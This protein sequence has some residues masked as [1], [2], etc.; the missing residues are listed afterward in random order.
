MKHIKHF[1]L[2]ISLL[3]TF[4][5]TVNAQTKTPLRR[6]ISPSSPV[7]L[8]HIDTHTWPDPQKCIDLIPTDIRPYLVMNISLSAGD[9]VRKKY[10]FT[11]CESW[12]RTCAE[13]RI[14]ATIQPASGYFC[15][16][17]DTALDDYE[18]FYKYPNFLG[19]NFAEQNW[20]FPTL[21]D[22]IT[23]LDLFTNLL[24]IANKYGGYLMVSNFLPLGNNSNAVGK[25]KMLPSFTAACKA[26][27]EN[28][29]VLDKF[30]SSSGYY[31]NE[32]GNLGT[33][34]SGYCGNY[35]IRFD[36]C[37]WTTSTTTVFPESSG[38]VAVLEHFMLTGATITDGPELT[39]AQ[40]IKQVSAVTNSSDGYT[41]KK[42]EVYDQFSNISIDN[43]R[44]IIDGTV[45]ILSKEEVIAR[46]KIAFVNDINDGDGWAT[47]NT[48]Q[49]LFTGLYAM[50]GE[51]SE[52]K[53][54][55]KKTGRYPSIPMVI[56]GGEYET[57]AFD[58]VVFKSKYATRWATQQ[59]KVNEFNA[60]FPSEYKGDMF[61]SRVKNKW[62]TYNPY[63]DVDTKSSAIIPLKYNTCDSIALNYSRY[64]LG[65]ITELEDKLTFYLNNYC[66]SSTYGMRVDTIKVYGSINEPTY[67][68]TDR[69]S[70]LA[71]SITKTWS[72]GVFSLTITHNGPLD[73]TINCSG[74]ATDRL[75]DYLSTKIVEPAPSP[76]Y[77]GPVQYEAENFDYKSVTSV[78]EITLPD[79]TAMGY[80]N[81][82]TN[83]Y[84]SLRDTVT[85]LKAGNYT[86][87]TKYCV[88]TGNV[89][90]LMRINGTRK[91]LNFLNTG[92][93][94]WSVNTQTITLKSGA[95]V[96]QFF[97]NSSSNN[98]YFDNI[99][100]ER[101]DAGVYNFSNDAASTQANTPAY[102]TQQSGSL[103]VVSYV[104][105]SSSTSNSLKAYTVGETN[106]T[107]VAD[108]ELFP[109][110]ATDY[111]VTWKGYAESTGG[112]NGMLLRGTGS[113]GSCAYANGMK[114]GY[115]FAS[116]YNSDGTVTLISYVAT[117]NGLT[118]KNSYTTSFQV[119]PNQLCF[120]RAKALGN[121]LSFECS[122]DNQTWEGA[123]STTFTDDSY[124]SG[125]TQLV[126]GLGSENLGW[127]MDDIQYSSGNITV[128]E[129]IMDGLNY[130][131][132]TGP[133]SVQSFNISG[134]SLTGDILIN[135]NEQFEISL[136]SESEYSSSLTLVPVDGTVP[137]TPIYVRLK[138]GLQVQAYSDTI[139]ISSSDIQSSYL[140]LNGAVTPQPMVKMYD[141]S[142][143]AASTSATTP[144]A[145]NMTIG[146]DNTATAGV[147]Q[148]TDANGLTSK[149]FKTYTVGQR[150][151]TGVVNLNLFSKTGTDYSVTW[152]EYIGSSATGYKVG[153]LLRG[154]ST[155][156]GSA[157]T[158]YVQ[159]LMQGYLFI[160]FTS[161]TST[162]F[163]IYKST[164]STSLN[165]LTNTSVSTLIPEVKQPVWYRASVSGSTNA[166][167]TFEYST[168]SVNWN[169]GSSASDNTS[170]FYKSGATQI[171]WGLSMTNLD[172]YFDDIIFNG[173]DTNSGSLPE[174]IVVSQASISGLNYTLGAGP[175]TS[176]Q[177][178]VS[179]T[180]LTNNVVITAPTNFEISLSENSSYSSTLTLPVVNGSVAETPVFVRLKTGLALNTYNGTLTLTSSGVL[181]KMVSLTGEVTLAS[182]LNE[183]PNSNASVISTRYYTLT[184]LEVR[185]S[186]NL[187][188]LYLV[189]KY[190]SDG[191]VSVSVALF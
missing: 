146:T 124:V 87:K 158:G 180:P 32:S 134:T 118:E 25:L 93:D 33:Y 16:F 81:F 144:P 84:A 17:S 147:V 40:A 82:G 91:Y 133:S 111:S 2:I 168:D 187:K 34:L 56:N 137:V 120:F 30:T 21:Q 19:W 191:A 69:S 161:G 129:F 149:M 153:M 78:S 140:I 165:T 179:G 185:P 155:N 13:N 103:G 157:S 188:G 55:F 94:T 31:D 132:G 67:T 164:S 97:S 88:P 173:L 177:L 76:I 92:T 80:V 29:V 12:I 59:A 71:S 128:S 126:W 23:R 99:I 100:I 110:T 154:Q 50:D 74:N 37:G 141:F 171:V 101:D 127:I 162:E 181:N 73:L 119:L 151:A 52:N 4:V 159:G 96:I 186:Q 116:Q 14:W 121:Q 1:K 122:T 68:F 145:V 51:W 113:N 43:F 61:V 189:K 135:S 166:L 102:V 46:T 172:F 136:N 72:D 104:D 42:F 176:K 39:W 114:Q 109:Y 105:N 60:L 58:T 175:S 182:G 20:G 112:K 89:S 22:Y 10:P 66:T 28:N 142:N 86:I 44:K 7:I 6:A 63:K 3:L 5:V 62:L 35:G 98:I 90:I 123:T 184:G 143:D 115:L 9:F 54:W 183:S 38:S 131:Q 107:G 79:Y 70:H 8:V 138:S 49:S 85:V 95:N 77:T 26:Y 152:K 65:V 36:E 178:L 47:C 139:E 45:P 167:L 160:V 125:G 169:T 83:A 108:L 163:R 15:N 18:Y 57:G 53:T 117:S 75:T 174:S 48:S 24:K 148:L 170:T 64:D 27:K 11:I 150:N 106:S 156:V 130:V 41:S 190:Y